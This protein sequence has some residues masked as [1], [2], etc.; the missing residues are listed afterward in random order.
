MLTIR[1]SES[2]CRTILIAIGINATMIFLTCIFG[3]PKGVADVFLVEGGTIL[4]MLA[5]LSAMLPPMRVPVSCVPVVLPLRVP[6]VLI[7]R[8]LVVSVLLH[9]LMRPFSTPSMPHQRPEPHNFVAHSTFPRVDG[10]IDV[11]T[12]INP[13]QLPTAPIHEP[14]LSHIPDAPLNFPLIASACVN[15]SRLKSLL[16]GYPSALL[17]FLISGFSFGF[18]IGFLGQVSSGREQNN[19]SASE[20]SGAVSKAIF[21]ELSRGHTMGPFTSPPFSKF[22]CSLLGAVPKKD[23]SQRIILDLSSPS[24]SSVND[25]IPSEFLR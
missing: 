23:G 7:L 20:K 14:D 19:L 12:A 9:P 1:H 6:V 8:V 18:R 11:S 13:T 2:L 17:D 10:S 5:P 24:G 4:P 22:H 3:V 16:E 21:R 15:I 25:G